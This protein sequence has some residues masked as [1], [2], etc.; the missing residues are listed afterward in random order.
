MMDKADKI[1]ASI[2]GNIIY[3]INK[4]SF[5]KRHIEANLDESFSVIKFRAAD[6]KINFKK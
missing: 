4:I 2:G 1:I 3:E 5:N 6:L